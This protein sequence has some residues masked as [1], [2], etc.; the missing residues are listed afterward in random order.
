MTVTDVAP[1]LNLRQTKKELDAARR[2]HP[3]TTAKAAPEKKAA[4]TTT[5]ATKRPA[6][7]TKTATKTPAKAAT[8][9]KAT[10]AKSTTAAK[11]PAP[12]DKT[13]RKAPAKSGRAKLSWQGDVALSGGEEIGRRVEQADGK[14]DAIVKVDG[15]DK[16]IATGKSRNGAY[17]IIVKYHHGSGDTTTQ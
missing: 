12:T 6:A 11:T 2:R 1:I 3:A 4:Q 8:A 13:P 5:A 17:A 9:A 10:P 7:A 14:Y 16:T 15:V